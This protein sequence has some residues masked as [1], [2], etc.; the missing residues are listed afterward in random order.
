MICHARGLPCKGSRQH[1]HF[2]LLEK[3]VP[4]E[5]L[6]L[7]TVYSIIITIHQLPF[8]ALHSASLDDLRFQSNKRDYMH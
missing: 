8:Y 4:A 5:I 3:C 6:K 7:I 1:R 2:E